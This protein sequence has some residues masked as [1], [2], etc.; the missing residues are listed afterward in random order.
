MVSSMRVVDRAAMIRMALLFLLLGGLGLCAWWFMIRMPLES[1]DGPL[2]LVSQEEERVMAGLERDVTR[3]A[4]EIGERNVFTPLAL[5]AAAEY[6]ESELL[7]AGY[8]VTSQRFEVR[9]VECRNLEVEIQG[10]GRAEEII[11]VGAHYDSVAGS[12][13][14]NDNGSGVAAML[15]LARIWADL[16]PKRTLRFVAFVNEEPPFFQ[17][18]EMGSAVY[19]RHCRK[20]GD[21]IVAMLSL[22]TIGYYTSAGGS[23]K[24][25]FPV[26]VFYPGQGDFIG[27]VSNT[28]NGGLVR[29]CITV[30]RTTTA[31]PSQGGALPGFLPG[32]GWSDHWAFWQEGYPAL[33]ITDTAPYRY[34]YYHE[35]TDTP[36]KLD[37]ERMARVL[38]GLNH[39]VNDLV[40]H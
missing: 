4:G 39:V 14:A 10:R 33:M 29:R 35:A 32:V 31:F 30:F 24:Y 16:E 5:V 22:E 21:D 40:N 15:A 2:P 6:I 20:R 3:L 25:P 12:P 23:Q 18:E 34:P 1:Y 38:T 11:V 26:G 13:G 19:A 8:A 27:F 36:D 9:G 37:Y 28:G 17:N 7:L